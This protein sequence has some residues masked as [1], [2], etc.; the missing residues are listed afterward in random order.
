MKYE[1][2]KL[3]YVEFRTEGKHIETSRF[4]LDSIPIYKNGTIEIKD[5]DNKIAVININ[6]PLKSIKNVLSKIKQK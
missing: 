6:K 4:Q 1:K 5:G 3:I 2:I